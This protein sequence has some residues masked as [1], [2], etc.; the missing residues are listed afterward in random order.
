METNNGS[1][2]YFADAAGRPV[3]RPITSSNLASP[4]TLI[5]PDRYEFYT[6]NDNG[7]LVKRQMTI[8]EIQN[9]IAAGGNP[10]DGLNNQSL[11]LNQVP[12]EENQVSTFNPI[13]P[14]YNYNSLLTAVKNRR[15]KS[16]RCCR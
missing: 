8:P 15:N 4:V 9:I 16:S 12:L 6:F 5:N 10:I 14:S 13:I 3:S 7:D 11:F 2:K 1:H